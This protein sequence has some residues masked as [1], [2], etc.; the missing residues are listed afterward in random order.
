MGAD[1]RLFRSEYLALQL[2][3][4][5]QFVR[6]DEREIYEW[7]SGGNVTLSDEY[8]MPGP[9][10][11]APSKYLIEPFKAIKDR[12][13]RVVTVLKPVQSGGTLLA[14][15]SV[16][17]FIRNRPGPV[18]WNMQTD[19]VAEDHAKARAIPTIRNCRDLQSLLP[20]DSRKMGQ[21]GAEFPHMSLYIQGSTPA[22]LQSKSILFLINDELWRW[23][24][25][26]YKWAMARV[27][28]FERVGIS[29]VLNISQPGVAGD[30]LDTEYKKGSQEEWNI[31]CEHCQFYYFPEFTGRRTGEKAEKLGAEWGMKW[32][33][34]EITRPNETWNIAEVIKTIRYECPECGKASYDSA[35]LKA[36]WNASGRYAQM[37]P[38]APKY[39]RSFRWN[40]I[41]ID[42]WANIVEQFLE[43]MEAY[44]RG[45]VA[46]LVT[47]KQQKFTEP[48]DP[49]K[50]HAGERSQTETYE[51]QSDWPDEVARGLMVDVQEEHF[52]VEVRQFAKSGDSRQLFFGKVSTEDELRKIQQDWKVSDNCCFADSSF[53]KKDN[54]NLRRVYAMLCRFNWTGF[55]GEGERLSYPHEAGV[56][57]FVYKLYSK[58]EWGDPQS[59]KALAGRRFAKYFKFATNPVADIVKRIREGKGAKWVNPPNSAEHTRQLFGEQKRKV[60]NKKTNREEW[61]WVQTRRDNHAF[62]LWKMFVVFCLMHPKIDLQT[63]FIPTANSE[64]VLVE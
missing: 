10:D 60:I 58:P 51:I 11:V 22:Q 1:S 39:L 30:E 7:A 40:S 27:T 23:V 36:Q 6:N 49:E 37:N 47:L 44:H 45:I 17:W 32:D 12:S 5:I 52:W 42:P 56:G 2:S 28:A 14:D 43:A 34:N 48:D 13:V 38:N 24:A 31:E 16:P 50:L 9:F 54:K 63:E 46:A 18:M 41:P 15:I 53:I 21:H 35:K 33:T 26:R 4:S 64:I 62:D 55:R 29:K 59:G 8:A 25:G 61:G 3:D 57:K 20:S 19:E